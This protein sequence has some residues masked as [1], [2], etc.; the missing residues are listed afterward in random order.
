M[1]IALFL[2]ITTFLYASSYP[3]FS[4]KELQTTQNMR[5]K[6]RILDYQNTIAQM[7]GLPKQKQL[8]KTNFY[9]NQLLPQYDSV[10]NKEEDHWATPKEFLLTG[11]GDCEDYV[12]IK[13]F[14]LLKLGFDESKLYITVVKEKYKGGMHMVLSYFEKKNNSPLILDNLSFRILKLKKRK[15]LQVNLLINSTGT[16]RLQQDRLVKVSSVHQ[17]YK[18]LMKNIENELNNF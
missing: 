14:T 6:N 2:L 7:Q 13:Y 17:K 15:D 9:L 4:Q 5:T 16:Y 12:I 18:I 1:R 8:T 11:Y 3:F 10:I